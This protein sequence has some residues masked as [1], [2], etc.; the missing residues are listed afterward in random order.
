M[1]K[2]GRSVGTDLS[3]VVEKKV[4]FMCPDGY[5]KWPFFVVHNSA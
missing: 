5:E 3:G 4:T 1:E 2:R